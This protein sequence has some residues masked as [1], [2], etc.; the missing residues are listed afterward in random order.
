MFDKIVSGFVGLAVAVA[1]LFSGLIPKVPQPIDVSALIQQE[2]Q[3]QLGASI[4]KAVANFQTS[5]QQRMTTSSTSMVLAR[6]TDTAGNSLSGYTCLTIDEG[7]TN[8][9]HV[10]GTASSTTISSLIRGLDPTDGNLENSSLKK[11]HAIGASVKI[12]DFLLTITTR[13]LNG[14]ESLPNLLTYTSGTACSG[15]ASSSAI[16]DK[17]YIDSIAVAG[18]SNANETTKGIIELSTSA[19]LALGT[20]LGGTGARLVAPLDLFTSSSSATKVPVLNSSGYLDSTFFNLATGASESLEFT[21]N[22]AF[23]VKNVSSSSFNDSVDKIV[24]TDGD[25]LGTD[26]WLPATRLNIA[27]SASGDTLYHNGTSFT[28]L[29]VGSNGTGLV[30]SAGFPSWTN[31]ARSYLVRGAYSAPSDTNLNVMASVSVPANLLG[32]RGGFKVTILADETSNDAVIWQVFYGATSICSQYVGRN[33]RAQINCYMNNVESTSSQLVW[34]DVGKGAG[35]SISFQG[36]TYT[37]TSENTAVTKS[38]RVT[39]QRSA[40]TGGQFSTISGVFI[41]TY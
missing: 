16:C 35:G 37:T 17:A 34:F 24:R 32:K 22:N 23:L 25:S 8:E 28:R 7:G 14:Q 41:Q 2:V 1:S 33:V 4:P 12:T 21:G 10:C 31:V 27:A 13:M 19:E 9:E 15:L 29:A 20:S 30:A 11:P 36:N 38:L 6:G 39:S 40:A 26:L 5:L 18:A 3:A